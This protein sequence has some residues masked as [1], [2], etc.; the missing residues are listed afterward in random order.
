MSY[1]ALY[2]ANSRQFLD[3][4]PGSRKLNSVVYGGLKGASTRDHFL[5]FCAR[6]NAR[7][8]FQKLPGIF[9]KKYD[10]YNTD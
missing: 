6:K 2:L 10:H 1:I 3:P 8:T 4:V 5:H 7:K 9:H